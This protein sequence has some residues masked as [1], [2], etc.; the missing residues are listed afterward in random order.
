M[1][2]DNLRENEEPR[3]IL[4]RLR[5]R[6]WPSDDASE[7]DEEPVPEPRRRAALRLD[8]ARGVRV[9]VRLSAAVFN[10][11][12]VVADGLKVGQQQVVNLDRA[13]PDMAERILDFLSGVTYALDGTVEKVGEKVYL[14]APANV[15]VEV[16]SGDAR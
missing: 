10:D 1:H 9:S 7:Y 11:A 3:G 6:I 2:P 14:F 13:T 4:A 16:D 12:R 8:T 15:H 5:D